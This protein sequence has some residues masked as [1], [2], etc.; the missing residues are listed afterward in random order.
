VTDDTA[1][2]VAIGQRWKEVDP[3][4]ERV[5]EIL[6]LTDDGKRARIRTVGSGGWG[7]WAKLARFNGKR[8]GYALVQEAP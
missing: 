5:V 8:G 2:V 6:E 4:T 3:R 1:P 7:S